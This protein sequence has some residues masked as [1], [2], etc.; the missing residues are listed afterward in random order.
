MATVV[1]GLFTAGLV[2]VDADAV[3]LQVTVSM[4]G[5]CGVDPVF[6]MREGQ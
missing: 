1:T 4:V 3:Q 5:T 6:I 2:V